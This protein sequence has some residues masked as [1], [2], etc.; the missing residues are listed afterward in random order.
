MTWCISTSA[1]A[2]YF[3]YEFQIIQPRGC[4][5]CSF[6][7]NI[8]PFFFLLRQKSLYQLPS[9]ASDSISRSACS[10][11]QHLWSLTEAAGRGCDSLY[12]LTFP[13]PGY[14]YYSRSWW[15]KT[16][17]RTL[18]TSYPPFTSL[19][20]TETPSVTQ[21]ITECELLH[22][23]TGTV[24]YW[25]VRPVIDVLDVIWGNFGIH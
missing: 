21:H 7:K 15:G 17:A 1:N 16:E 23:E 9:K 18:G 22:D 19:H 20:L 14:H 10:L 2:D 8:S 11:P 13:F 3:M 12:Q 6:N 4:L 24:G 5:Q 25:C